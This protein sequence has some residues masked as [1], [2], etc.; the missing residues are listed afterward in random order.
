MKLL[1]KMP[2]LIRLK[3]TNWTDVQTNMKADKMWIYETKLLTSFVSFN[4]TRELV[5]FYLK[6]SNIMHQ[7]R[8]WYM[9]MQINLVYQLSKNYQ[10]II[11]NIFFSIVPIAFTWLFY[12][13]ILFPKLYPGLLITHEIWCQIIFLMVFI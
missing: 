12:L 4:K 7:L 6:I 2:Y 8:F 11:C 5:F 3:M 1:Y 10:I 9:Q 13:K